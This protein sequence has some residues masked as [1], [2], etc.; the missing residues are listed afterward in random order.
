MR[1]LTRLVTPPN[2]LVLDLFAGS[3]TTGAAAVTEGFRAILIEAD[4][5][6]QADIWER[7]AWLFVSFKAAFQAPSRVSCPFAWHSPR[8]KNRIA[9][10]QR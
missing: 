2:G 1:W 6:Y 10:H 7:L 9:D 4:P 5:E 3:G 8:Q